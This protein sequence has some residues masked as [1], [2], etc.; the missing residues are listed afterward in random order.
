MPDKVSRGIA[1]KA[2]VYCKRNNFDF[3]S[4]ASEVE[5]RITSAGKTSPEM[6]SALEKL[7]NYSESSNE[8]TD[9]T[10][11]NS[12]KAP[13]TV[14]NEDLVLE[15]S[16]AAVFN[17]KSLDFI[18]D[19]MIRGMAK[20]SFMAGKRSNLSDNE[21]IDLIIKDLDEN[22]K[23]TD[24]IKNHLIGLKS[25]DKMESEEANKD[26]DN[27]GVKTELFDIKSLD[28]IEDRVTRGSAKKIYMAGKRLKQSSVEVIDDILK[29]LSDKLVEEVKLKLKE[30]K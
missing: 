4:M 25:S 2:V 21:K 3:S 26:V 6:S 29:E 11:D 1:K 9:S 20:K 23:N 10:S 22:E 16:T 7:K 19:K 28:I 15:S 13:D 14:K 8:N 18:E 30:L 24:E 27:A 17:V 12:N 5:N